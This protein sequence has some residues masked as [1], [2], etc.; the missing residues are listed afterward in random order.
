MPVV[1]VCLWVW[2]SPVGMLHE[3][4]CTC[5]F[6]C[7]FFL[8][9]VFLRKKFFVLV[10]LHL[11]CCVLCC[12][13]LTFLRVHTVIP[14]V[15]AHILF[16]SRALGD[17]MCIRLV[18]HFLFVLFLFFF[19]VFLPICCCCI[20][21]VVLCVVLVYQF[22]VFVHEFC[23]CC[24]CLGLIGIYWIDVAC[25]DCVVFVFF[26]DFFHKF[27]PLFCCIFLLCCAR[28]VLFC[29]FCVFVHV[30]CLCCDCLGLVDILDWC[31][32]F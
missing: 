29:R 12:T 5:F 31:C 13:V 26:C 8:L 27:N 21:L 18:V 7:H 15:H 30:F 10:L 6:S 24:G 28:V 3:L 32:M 19:I 17:G 4:S 22:C 20:F 11:S 9:L 2:I 16:V 1:F 23:L 14:L 25:F